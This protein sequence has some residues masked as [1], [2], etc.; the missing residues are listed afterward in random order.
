MLPVHTFGARTTAIHLGGVQF[1]VTAIFPRCVTACAC[2]CVCV[3]VL[4]GPYLLRMHPGRGRIWALKTILKNGSLVIQ[5]VLL[6]FFFSTHSAPS[7]FTGR[8]V[9]RCVCRAPLTCVMRAIKAQRNR[10]VSG[11]TDEEG[12]EG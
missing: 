2:Q 3:C 9:K 7:S 10:W 11:Q 5:A 8:V 1:R 6:A 12:N 4:C